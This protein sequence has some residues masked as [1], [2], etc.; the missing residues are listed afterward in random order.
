MQPTNYYFLRYHLSTAEEVTSKLEFIRT[1]LSSKAVVE[2]FGHTYQ[3]L[4]LAYLVNDNKDFLTGYLVK[5]SRD[6]D[7]EVVDEKLTELA[8]TS[9]KNKVVGKVRFIVVLDSSL[10]AFHEVGNIINRS[11]FHNKFTELFEKNFK[12]FFVN[13]TTSPIIEQYSFLEE[14]KKFQTTKNITINLVPSNPRFSERWKNIDERLRTSHITNYKEV[15]ENKLKGSILIDKETESKI[16]M[17][18]DGYGEASAEG[19]T[20]QGEEK[21]ISTKKANK[22]TKKPIPTE[23]TD[24]Q[25][26]LTLLS[27]ILDEITKR[28]GK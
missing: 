8:E 19:I 10:I 6:Y 11:I 15:L 1:G 23:I 4:E 24:P 7:E 26:I 12:N 16:Y 28:T 2:Q 21:K 3:F 27:P 5:Y 25:V 13:F 20:I 9:I 18:E 22:V 14:V 17:S